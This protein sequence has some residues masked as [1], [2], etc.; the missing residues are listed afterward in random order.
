[1]M[2]ATA[3]QRVSRA[4]RTA[5]PLR[6]V[7]DPV[8]GD[9]PRLAL[10]RI[11]SGVTVLT[12]RWKG[13]PHGTTVSAVVAISRDP[14][15][16]GVCLRAASAFTAMVSDHGLFSVNVLSNDQ[17]TVANRFADSTRRPGDLQF[18][19]LS[20]STDPVS[21]APLLDACVAH[22]TCQVT[23]CQRIGDHDLIVAEVIGGQPGDGSP[24]LSFAGR[25]HVES[26]PRIGAQEVRQR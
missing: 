3:G 4:G 15:V 16:V 10:R 17:A 8:E 18:A 14:L 23:G 24:L 6:A 22:L 7:P 21:G 12:T 13:L 2:P 1:M 19:G 25:L 5:A 26:V 9:L 11:V 20:W